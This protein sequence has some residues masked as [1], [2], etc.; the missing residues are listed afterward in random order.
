MDPKQAKAAFDDTDTNGDGELDL[1]E[2]EAAWKKH[3]GDAM[4]EHCGLEWE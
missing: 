3:D 4:M 1:A 2:V